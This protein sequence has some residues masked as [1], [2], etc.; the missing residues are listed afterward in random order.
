M[1]G[2]W[3]HVF[4]DEM[5]AARSANAAGAAERER[6]QAWDHFRSKGWQNLVD[7]STPT[8]WRVKDPSN[9]KHFDDIWL[10]NSL[11]AMSLTSGVAKPPPYVLSDDQAYPNHLLVW[12]VL[13]LSALQQTWSTPKWRSLQ[14]PSVKSVLQLQPA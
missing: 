5:A 13:D 2:L 4:P 11:A 8:N 6:Q 10:Q 14:A 1:F 3:Y 7:I 9:L 12:A